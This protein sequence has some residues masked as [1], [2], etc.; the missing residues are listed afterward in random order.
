MP[1]P[2]AIRGL[3]GA[4]ACLGLACGPE[5]ATSVATS[6][7]TSGETTAVTTAFTTSSDLTTAPVPTG[8]DSTTQQPGTSTGS[9]TA[10]VEPCFDATLETPRTTVLYVLEASQWMGEPWDDDGDPAT[11]SVTLWSSARDT[12]AQIGAVLDAGHWETGF[13]VYPSPGAANTYSEEQCFFDG[14]IAV[15][16][17]KKNTAAILAAL[18]TEAEL[19]GGTPVTAAIDQAAPHVRTLIWSG[20]L[21]LLLHSPPNCGAEADGAEALLEGLDD[22]LRD[23]LEQLW[24]EEAIKTVVIL[25]GAPE[26]T[27]AA[28]D[29]RADDVDMTAYLGELAAASGSSEFYAQ[30]SMSDLLDSLKT[31]IR[32]EDCVIPLVFDDEDPPLNYDTMRFSLDDVEVPRVDDCGEHGWL[33]E[34]S[35]PPPQSS[36]QQRLC[37]ATCALYNSGAAARYQMWCD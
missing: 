24:V 18:P 23:R 31:Q 22:G 4:L 33:W 35:N 12:V 6:G 20:F 10:M 8:S 30:A 28:M 17:A 3:R 15:N 5:S 2:R 25:I 29:A 34:L 27:S 19:A 21:I 14:S 9:T 7:A 36:W 37:P 11:P 32:S 13:V 1:A 16:L 26:D